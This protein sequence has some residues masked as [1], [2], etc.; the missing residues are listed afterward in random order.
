MTMRAN[1]YLVNIIGIFFSS[2]FID[3]PADLMLHAID[4]HSMK[5]KKIDLLIIVW[6][7]NFTV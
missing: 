7:T 6:K 2:N 4:S 5:K 3:L 1:N